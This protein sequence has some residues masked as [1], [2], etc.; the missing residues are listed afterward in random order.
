M[1]FV[2][3]LKLKTELKELNELKKYEYFK[4][5][6]LKTGGIGATGAGLCGMTFGPGGAFVCG[7]GGAI[8][9]ALY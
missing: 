9:G 1:E 6:A 2:L 3:D 4:F 8:Y 5:K 7:L